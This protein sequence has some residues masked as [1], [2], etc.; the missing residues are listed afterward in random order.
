MD[1]I[2][3][4]KINS[5]PEIL[6]RVLQSQTQMLSELSVVLNYWV[7]IL[8]LLAKSPLKTFRVKIKYNV[9]FRISHAWNR[10]KIF[11]KHSSFYF[12]LSA[13]SF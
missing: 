7:G 3:L 5:L 13:L 6:C 2:E 9:V 1:E 12:Q 10:A 8:M 4:E 11:L